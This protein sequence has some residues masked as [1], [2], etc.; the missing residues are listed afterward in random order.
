MD[1]AAPLQPVVAG[2][3]EVASFPGWQIRRMVVKLDTGA[4]TG[5]IDCAS[6][7]ELGDGKVRFVLRLHRRSG[8]VSREFI[9]P[10]VRREHVRS[11]SGH[12]SDRLFVTTKIKLGRVTRTVELSL[13]A[14]HKMVHRVLLG[15]K[16]LAG[17]FLVD[18]GREF[19]L[20][21]PKKRKKSQRRGESTP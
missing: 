6:I 13:T 4:A 15:R 20:P 9:H 11:A 5:A 18:S 16:A 1:A 7:E 17:A 2:W 12:G 8:D 19:L 14:R 10:I 21:R 3:R